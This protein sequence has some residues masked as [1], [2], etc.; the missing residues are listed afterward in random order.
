MPGIPDINPL[1]SLT[2]K[3]V[4]HMILASI[5]M[6]EMGLSSIL[7]AE[8]EKIQRFVN[9]EDVCL[10]DILQLNRSVERVLRGMVNNQILLQHKL[11]DVLIFEEQ[12]RSNRY[13]D[14]E[15]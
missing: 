11:E 15:S 14:P 10:Q 2:R 4:I 8:G 7:Y 13:P 3:E 1:I 12:S 6:E 5:A 9:D